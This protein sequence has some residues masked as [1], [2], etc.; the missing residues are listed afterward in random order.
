M[1]SVLVGYLSIRIKM[2]T[3]S[4]EGS[5][6]CVT[7]QQLE[8][9]RP[10]TYCT[11]ELSHVI[12]TFLL[13]LHQKCMILTTRK[14]SWNPAGDWKQA[15]ID[16]ITCASGTNRERTI[17][18]VQIKQTVASLVWGCSSQTVHNVCGLACTLGL[19]SP[20]SS[21]VFRSYMLRVYECVFCSVPFFCLPFLCIVWLQLHCGSTIASG[22]PRSPHYCAPLVCVF[23]LQRKLLAWQLNQPKPNLLLMKPRTRKNFSA[24]IGSSLTA[25]LD[26]IFKQSSLRSV[27]GIIDIL[28]LGVLAPYSLRH[29]NKKKK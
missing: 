24:Q 4:V 7:F 23:N 19:T 20:L 29:A 3:K 5:E 21:Y 28:Y 9:Q 2:E 27:P 11:N 26:S 14:A 8:I 22:T 6:S 17:V 25:P 18:T 10:G 16:P 13:F 15:H 1:K 12:Y